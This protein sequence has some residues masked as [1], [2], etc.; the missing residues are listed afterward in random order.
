MS[1]SKLWHNSV[2][3]RLLRR[4]LKN[5]EQ[6]LS[7]I[8][9]AEQ[10]QIVDSDA[11]GMLEGVLQVT[12]MQVRDSMIPLTE[13]V[14]VDAEQTL[15]QLIQTVVD[16]LHSRYPVF[17]NDK[18]IG[19][20]LAKDL[21]A[22]TQGEK[23]EQF[24]LDKIIQPLTTVPETQHLNRLLKEFK[25]LRSHMAIVV[26]EYGHYTGLI[27]MEDILEQIVGDIEDEY[28]YDEDS[29][30]KQY[31]D[32]SIIKANV[33]LEDFNAHFASNL[34]SEHYE[35]IGGFV[36]NEL[37]HIPKRGEEFDLF[38]LHFRILHADRRRI[39]LLQVSQN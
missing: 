5:R 4:R 6:L 11:E 15:E 32:Y 39:R 23:R 18:V 30:I 16:N 10:E 24:S 14:R 29:G 28:D 22:F 38:S 9:Q 12:E 1:K 21:L 17:E 25:A 20:L 35:T 26:D 27:T 33:S 7:T 31:R 37:G 13:I 19:I 3:Q 8:R 36:L 2:L 34:G